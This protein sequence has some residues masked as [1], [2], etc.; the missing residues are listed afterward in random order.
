MYLCISTIYCDRNQVA[1]GYTYIAIH[2]ANVCT[3][4]Y[5]AIYMYI[6]RIYVLMYIHYILRSQYSA[7]GCTYIAIYSANKC[8]HT[9]IAIYVHPANIYTYVYPLYIHIAIK[10]QVDIHI[11]R[12]ILRIYVHIYTS[13]YMYILR[14]YTL[15]YIH[16][17]YT[18]QLS[19]KLIYTLRILRSIADRKYRLCYRARLQKRPVILRSLLIEATPYVSCKLIYI[20]CK[21]CDLLQW[22]ALSHK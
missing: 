14:I 9:Y 13:Q 8:T 2:I 18:S 5:I 20:Y 17:I 22:M 15:M 4:L 6:L 21:Y 16:Y 11:L 12:S 10:L 3:H 7:S 19:C 1:S